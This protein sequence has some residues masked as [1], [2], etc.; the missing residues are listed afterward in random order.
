M[1]LEP[2]K[3]LLERYQILQNI[4][5]GETNCVYHAIDL[6]TNMD[7]AVKEN[8]ITTEEYARQFRLE[9]VILANL[10]HPNLPRVTDFFTDENGQYLVMDYIDG[11]DLHERIQRTGILTELEAIWLGAAVCDALTYLHTRKPIIL[12]RNI[13]PDA[14][15][16]SPKGNIFL[17]G[18]RLVKA[19]QAGRVPGPGKAHTDPRSDI[20]SLGATLY[21][22][23]TNVVPE[24]GLSR[25]MDH[26]QLTPLIKHNPKISSSLASVI[27]KAL[28]VDPA[29][30][31]Q[32]A[33]D[34]KKALLASKT[35]SGQKAK[36]KWLRWIKN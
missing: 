31:F 7:V 1:S 6:E 25:A 26:V 5:S 27:E 3:L 18:F 11:E 23:L 34:L 10:R 9:A 30:R 15:R 24:D 17:V 14:I 22:S 21:Y 33:E 20:Y 32:S 13:Q 12:H 2:G 8:R 35:H 28:A 19:M 36:H 29:S 16:I 4:K